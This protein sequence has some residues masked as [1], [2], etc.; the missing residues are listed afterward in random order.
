[1]LIIFVINN[2]KTMLLAS[3]SVPDVSVNTRQLLTS[4]APGLHSERERSCPST[5]SLHLDLGSPC[6]VIIRAVD[7][8]PAA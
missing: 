7:F 5:R 8:S 3:L 6:D 4:A 1:M 2:D